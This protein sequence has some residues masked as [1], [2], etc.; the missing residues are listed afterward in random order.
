MKRSAVTLLVFGIAFLLFA[1]TV[2]PYM[3]GTLRTLPTDLD[4]TLTSTGSRGVTR[5]EHIRSE[6]TPKIDEI[7]I[8]AD[9]TL[10]TD[11]GRQLASISE[12]VTLI[13]HSR[14]PVFEP[15]AT[16]SGTPVDSENQT[17]E[18]L[19]YFFP[20]NTLRQSYLYYDELLGEAEY[21]DYTDRGGDTYIFHQSLDDRRLAD[22]R[23][24][25]VDRTLWV[26]RYSGLVLDRHETVTLGDAPTQEFSF[27]DATRALMEDWAA[28]TTR[29]LL[30][31]KVLA[32][33]AKFLGLVLIGIGLWRTGF[34]HGKT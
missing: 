16:I 4:F 20:A 31:A 2:P 24:Y 28:E 6:P 18:G 12:S 15:T 27:T 34:L 30:V 5:T 9:Q 23:S 7:R 19:R 17:R 10:D 14:F 21:V 25:S 26:D 3:T 13:G 33:S 1:F 32:F 8:N 29:G 11:D 22:G